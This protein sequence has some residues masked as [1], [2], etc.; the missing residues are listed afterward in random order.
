MT[1]LRFSARLKLVDA[2]GYATRE[3]SRFL[4]TQQQFV[5][6]EDGQNK[7]AEAK[8]VADT[9]KTTADTVTATVDDPTTG[10]SAVAS[11]AA[12]AET[13]ANAV[14]DEISDGSTGL[15]A[16]KTVA[17]AA[18]ATANTANTT[19]SGINTKLTGLTGYTAP[20]VSMV[21][22]QA[23]VQGIADALEDLIAELK[24]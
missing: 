1:N 9:A 21:P 5:A 6:G 7:V 20:T 15:A 14:N 4:S 16:T 22:T 23:E 24:A 12:A 17:D 2:E 19:A 10:L 8:T 18:Q 11:T 3:F 13:T